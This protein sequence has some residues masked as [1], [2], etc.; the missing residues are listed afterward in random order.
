MQ[1]F[2]LEADIAGFATNGSSARIAA[3]DLCLSNRERTK[4]RLGILFQEANTSIQ[5]GVCLMCFDGIPH[6]T[7]IIPFRHQ[8]L[9]VDVAF[10]V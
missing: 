8:H 10:T 7:F 5:T 1:D 6:L 2:Q 3:P 9:A 4:G